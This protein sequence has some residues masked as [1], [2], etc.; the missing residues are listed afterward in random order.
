MYIQNWDEPFKSRQ[1]NGRERERERESVGSSLEGD[2]LLFDFFSFPMNR[3][4]SKNEIN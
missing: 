4:E 1:R 2:W 3:R